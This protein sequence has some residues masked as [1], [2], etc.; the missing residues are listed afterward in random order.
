MCNNQGGEMKTKLMVILI[1]F[2]MV[3]A[4]GCSAVS[5]A[6]PIPAS[7]ETSGISVYIIAN[8]EGSLKSDTD[9]VFTQ[10]NG[11]LIDNPPL[12]SNG[13]GQATIAYVEKTVAT[14]GNINYT[15]SIEVDTAS[16]GSTGS[17]LE[18]VRQID[19]SNEGDGDSVGRMYSSESVMIEQDATAASGA[20]DCC[21]WGTGDEGTLP[22][23]SVRVEA[24]SEVNLKEGSVN[25]DSTA[26]TVSNDVDSGIELT[27]DVSIEGSGQTGNDKAVGSA[28]VFTEAIIMEGS[29]NQTNQ[30]TSMT[31][32]ENVRVNGLIQISMD[33]GYSSP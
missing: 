2:A 7:N 17:N 30:T 28:E 21:L 15:Q 3:M 24:G 19:Y 9:I 31:Y 26:R 4:I 6:N 20:E 18:T 22:A 1:A 29:G 5:A 13:E 14:S 12:D 32:E 16:Q 11:N 10:G 33:T 27:Y 8:A 25:S 23:S